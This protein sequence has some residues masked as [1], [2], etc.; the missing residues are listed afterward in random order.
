M[1]VIGVYG[2]AG[3]RVKAD[4]QASEIVG[5][6]LGDIRVGI[7]RPY[8]RVPKTIAKGG[9]SR[10]GPLRWDAQTLADLTADDEAINLP[11][12]PGQHVPVEPLVSRNLLRF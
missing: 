4:L 2:A 6:K 12:Q 5:L 8:I 10:R 3:E 7:A 1:V 11:G 9:K